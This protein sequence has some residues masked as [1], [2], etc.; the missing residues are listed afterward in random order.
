MNIANFIDNLLVRFYGLRPFYN[1]KTK[2]DLCGQLVGCIAPHNS[3][4]VVGRIIGFSKMQAL[5]ASP[6]IHAAMRRDCDGDEAAVMLLLDMLLNFSREF[7]P[8]HRGGTQ[9]APLVLNAR[10]RAGEV[11]DMIFDIETIKEF[12][13]EFYEA[14]EI[15][16]PAWSVKIEQIK[17]RLN[18]EIAVFKNLN[19]TH[20]TSNIN[21]GITCSAYKKLETMQEKVQKQMELVEKIRAVDTTDVARLIIERHLI[22]DIRGNLRKF[23]MQEFRC[24]KCNEKFRRPP[25][26][27]VCSKCSGKIIFTISEGG[28]K[29][30]LEPA[31]SLATKYEVPPYIKQSLELTK[32]YIESIFGR[33]KEKQEALEK[34][35]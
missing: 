34:W 30:Y 1:I 8:A 9:D 18:D 22:R 27:G 4:A 11:D 20:E 15:Y 12:P 35:F 14:A 24:V 28:I 17:D 2:E 23:S 16:K 19:Y 13:L 21:D 29:K 3:A 5:L 26:Q 25:L 10:L 6:Y 7:L 33:E 32:K 31:L